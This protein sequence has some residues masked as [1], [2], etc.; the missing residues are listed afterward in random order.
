MVVKLVMVVIVVM[1][2]VLDMVVVVDIVAMVQKKLTSCCSKKKVPFSKRNVNL[3]R[4]FGFFL[5]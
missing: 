5:G 3:F 4:N 2:V 1:V